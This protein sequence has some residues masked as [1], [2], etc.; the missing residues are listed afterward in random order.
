M[1]ENN[2]KFRARSTIGSHVGDQLLEQEYQQ[3]AM[4]GWGLKARANEFCVR[5]K[6]FCLK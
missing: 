6:M 5:Y 3:L 4:R 2:K 1:R